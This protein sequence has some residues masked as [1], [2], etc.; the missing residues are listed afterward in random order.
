M[1]IIKLFFL[2]LI[3]PG[4]IL[5]QYNYPLSP[6][7]NITDTFYGTIINDEYRWLENTKSAD[8]I[9]WIGEQNKITKSVLGRAANKINSYPQIDKYAY[10]EYSNPVKEGDYYFSYSFYNSVGAPAL[11]YRSA[12]NQDPT[13][14]VDP[15]FISSKDVILLKTFAL[16]GDSKL[17]AYQYS[18]NGSD[19]AEIEVVSMG[20]GNR[21][22]DHLVNVKFSDISWKDDG[23][24]Y[25]KFPHKDDFSETKGQEI[26]YHQIGTEQSEDKLIFR[27]LND[28]DMFFEVT[29]TS[30]ERFLL[31]KENNEKTGSVRIYHIDYQSELKSMLPLLTQLK[32]GDINILDNINNEFFA[33]SYK[34]SNNGM[35]IKFDP[36]N[37]R[38]WNEVVPENSKA[39]LIKAKLLSD[40]IITIYLCQGKQQIIVF[41][42]KG[43]LLTSMQLPYG[44]SAHGFDGEMNDEELLFSYS[45]YTS[46]PV[47]YRFNTKT[48]EKKPNRTTIANFD[49]TQFE[50]KE[51]EYFSKDSTKIPLFIIYK[52]GI[53]FSGENATLLSAYGGFGTIVKPSF[54]PGIV[55]FLLKGGIYAFAHIRGGGDNGAA[56]ATMGKG[57]QK[58]NSFDDFIAAAE[59]LINNNYTNAG[60]LAITGSSN[61]G[62]VVAVAMIQRPDLFKVA[63]PVVAPTDMLRFEKFT[64]GTYH[65][66]EYGSIND[67]AGFNSLLSYSPLHN[68]KEDENYPATLIIT[69]ENDDRVPPFHSYKFVA[70]LQNRKA[71]T[72]PVIVRVEKDAG[73]YGAGSSLKR[74]IK[75]EADIYDFILFHLFSKE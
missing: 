49:F 52:K 43:N 5:A 60:K 55:H 15:N 33:V 12:L 36:Q 57:K 73:H 19:F 30:D 70:K 3:L 45:G 50:T 74:I 62:L 1:I 6:K 59:F 56:W 66:D 8:I 42:L 61:G 13:L 65:T 27:R 2:F 32:Q 53:N 46:P 67:S 69:S 35:I 18:R 48:F 37:P 64:V 14:I 47:V 68:I 4:Y 54:D 72:N 51:L 28:P 23:F 26:Y 7:I 29:T 40:K 20:T 63:V 39:L 22:N 24:F 41:D 31:I 9:N 10:A 44:Y 17:L 11:F 71:Q 58:Q 75:E 25:S 34:G 16:S 21:K 38:H